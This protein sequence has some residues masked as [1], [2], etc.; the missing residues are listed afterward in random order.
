MGWQY[1]DKWLLPKVNRLT[2]K[3][4]DLQ[5]YILAKKIIMSKYECRMDIQSTLEGEGRIEKGMPKDMTPALSFE[6]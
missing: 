1:R 3:A 2:I 5:N 4:R 6:R